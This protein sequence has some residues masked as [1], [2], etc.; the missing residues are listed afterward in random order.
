[1]DKDT[2]DTGILL[3]NLGTPDS[4]NTSDVRKYLREFLMD[5]YV[6]NAPSFIRAMIVYGFILPTRPKKSAE[7]Y[8]H[9]WTDEGSPLLVVALNFAR[10]CMPS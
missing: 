3:V 5:P 10:L 2:S 1:M 6:V 7:A 9:I 8:S 4:T